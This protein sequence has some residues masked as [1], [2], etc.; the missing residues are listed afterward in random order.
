MKYT[1]LLVHDE[2][3][4]LSS[5]RRAPVVDDSG[6]MRK[7]GLLKPGGYLMVGSA[8]SLTGM[9]GPFKPIQPSIYQK[10]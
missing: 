9:L 4:V 3:K 5:L 7:V 6:V 8:E 2:P 10:Q 1:V